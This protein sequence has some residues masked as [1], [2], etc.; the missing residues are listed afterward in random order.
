MGQ[1]SNAFCVMETF[2]S[3]N[4]VAIPKIYLFAWTQNYNNNN[5]HNIL[6]VFSIG[7]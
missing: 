5:P 3:T 6:A 2:R 4:T 1:R 7:F